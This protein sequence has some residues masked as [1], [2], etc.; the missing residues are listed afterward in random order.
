MVRVKY[1]SENESYQTEMVCY[2]NQADQIYIEI[3]NGEDDPYGTQH[4][5]LSKE[6]AKRL[7]KDLRR[8]ISFLPDGQTN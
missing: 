5:V 2:A 1:I 4:I 6:T 8:E 7:A 3:S